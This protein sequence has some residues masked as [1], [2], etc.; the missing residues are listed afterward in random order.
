MMTLGNFLEHAYNTVPYYKELFERNNINPLKINSIE[1]LS[2]IPSLSKRSIQEQPEQFI[3]SLY[4][5]NGLIMERTSGSTSRPLTIY[6]ST[7][8]LVLERL[9][10]TR[11]R[12]RTYGVSPSSRYC[13]F[14]LFNRNESKL[15]VDVIINRDREMALSLF[16][17]NDRLGEYCKH[18]IEF[19]PEWIFGP[20]T[21][22]YLLSQ[23]IIANK[24]KMPC[25][26]KY[27][28]LTGEVLTEVYRQKIEEVFN[29]IAVN[30]YGCTE[31]YGIALE[32]PKRKL[33]CLRD[34]AIVE[35]QKDGHTVKYGEKGNILI[36]GLNNKAM[37]FIRYEI[38]DEGTLFP[39]EVCNCGNKN[40]VLE[41]SAGRVTSYVYFKNKSSTSSGIFYYAIESVNANYENSILQFQV[42]Q[43]DYDSFKLLLV[44]DKKS[45]YSKDDI[46]NIFIKEMCKFEL[47]KAK[48]QIESV[49]EILPDEKTGKLKFF[50]SKMKI[51]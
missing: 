11:F 30:H 25:S 6:K 31:I 32:C 21:V 22:L 24:I 46:C 26:I 19:K 4:H 27:I 45:Q 47:D 42:I 8:D 5:I 3:S 29:C 12:H 44:I 33:H 41:V 23:Y 1:D 50:D 10:L 17:L 48:W 40:P 18:I 49:D 51:A 34:N 16:M 9:S 15:N 2:I 43:K 36:T 35:I 20:P 37:P 14:H 39:S 13:M 28:E 38:G 7:Q